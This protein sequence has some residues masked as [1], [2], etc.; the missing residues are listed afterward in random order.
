MRLGQ[1]PTLDAVQTLLT[2]N[3]HTTYTVRQIAMHV[4]GHRDES[5]L[6]AARTAIYRLRKLRGLNIKSEM[7]VGYWYDPETMEIDGV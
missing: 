3:P 2:S 5:E 6:A 7:G 1:N 4:Y